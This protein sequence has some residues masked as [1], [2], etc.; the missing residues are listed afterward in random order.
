MAGLGVELN[1]NS[2]A[3]YFGIVGECF[4][5]NHDIVSYWRSA[6]LVTIVELVLPELAFGFADLSN[7]ECLVECLSNWSSLWLCFAVN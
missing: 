1:R 3:A 2:K 7:D 6:G 4:V 5:R